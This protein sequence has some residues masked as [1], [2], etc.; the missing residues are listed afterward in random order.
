M[1]V[2]IDRAPTSTERGPV[3]IVETDFAAMTDEERLR[4]L[5]LEGFV[6]LPHLIDAETIARV[7]S[8]LEDIPL[9][10]APYSPE[11]AFAA[12]PP[13]WHSRTFAELIGHPPLVSL[14]HLALGES[15]VFMLGQY[16]RSGPGVPGL[17]LHSDYQPF[18]SKAKG[19][20]ESSPA[21]VRVLVYLDDL[22]V[23]RAAFTFLPRSHLSLHEQS[24]TYLRYE[25]HPGMVTVCVE[26]GGA[27]AFNVRC[28]HGTH[29]NTSDFRRSMLEYAY[30]PRWARCAGEVPEWDPALVAAAPPQARPFLAS[31]NVGPAHDF[32]P[33]FVVDCA[34][35]GCGALSP[36]RW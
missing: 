9:G 2:S 25:R 11:Q 29:P 33:P 12:T 14:L 19:Y 18:G 13:Q 23:E 1:T 5:E 34:S 6:V 3:R 17:A 8:E 22:T 7:K 26:A 28:F 35:S 10:F 24:N 4:H 16:V 31:R 20:E 32:E 27:I 15:P 21:T 36:G 30:R